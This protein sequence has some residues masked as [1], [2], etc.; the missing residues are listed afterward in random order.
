MN[1]LRLSREI[2]SEKILQ[3]GICDYQGLAQITYLTDDDHYIVTFADCQYATDVT[4]HEFEDY[5]IELTYK[6]RQC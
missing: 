3:Q 1:K 5:L 6:M 2:Y 4:I